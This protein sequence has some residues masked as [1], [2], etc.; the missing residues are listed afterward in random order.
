MW[1]HRPDADE[2]LTR[3][4][5]RGWKP[6][7]TAT[8]DGDVVLGHAA[9]AAVKRTRGF[10]IIELRAGD[11]ER[12]R[13]IR[14]RALADAPLAFATLLE[15]AEKLPI[16]RWQQQIAEL[17]NFVAVL[18]ERDVGMVRGAAYRGRENSAILISM[19][20]APCARGC[21][22]GDALIDAVI[23]WARKEQFVDVVLEVG[24]DNAAAIALY[25]RKGFEPTG[26]TTT[27]PPPRDHVREHERALRL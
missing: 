19:W 18:S 22:V 14:L 12:L 25:E 4:T 15:D 6:R 21:G 9:C 8:K 17:S 3:R 23:A 10:E 24:D 5:E 7:T 13:D 2:L 16:E 11:E 1:D 20:V 27:L 26:A